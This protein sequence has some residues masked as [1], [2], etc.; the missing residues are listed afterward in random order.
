MQHRRSLRKRTRHFFRSVVGPLRLLPD[1]IIIGAQKCGTTTLYNILSDHPNILAATKKEVHFFDGRF[2]KGM[3]WYRGHFPLKLTRDRL[4]QSLRQPVLTGEASPLYLF[5]PLAPERIKIVLP[6]VKMIVILRN[7]V[8][9]AYSHYQRERR[10]GFESLSFEEALAHEDERMAGE[11]EKML[12]PGINRS[13]NFSHY[14]YKARGLYA[15]QLR[16]WFS[17]FPREQFLILRNEDLSANPEETFERVYQF[18]GIPSWFPKKYMRHNTAEYEMMKP[19][20]RA[21]LIEYFKPH[22]RELSALL[23]SEMNWDK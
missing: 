13:Y 19:E 1:F 7:P 2:T 5:H 10:D 17:L 8:D 22:N 3:N 9:R 23:G 16:L 15:D 4:S 21:Q 6:G 18:L 12:T 20:T 14:S 11:Q